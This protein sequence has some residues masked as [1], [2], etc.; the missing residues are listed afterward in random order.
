MQFANSRERV[1]GRGMEDRCKEEVETV[2][3]GCHGS[4]DGGVWWQRI[5][6][7]ANCTC[8]KVSQGWLSR[9]DLLEVVDAA[10]DLRMIDD[11]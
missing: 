2:C 7:A 10:S 8:Y 5:T 6:K 11:R 1:G 4:A 3:R 9:Y